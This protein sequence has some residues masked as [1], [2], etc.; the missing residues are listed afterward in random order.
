M[1]GPEQPRRSRLTHAMDTI[2]RTT[3]RIRVLQATPDAPAAENPVDKRVSNAVP[4]DRGISNGLSDDLSLADPVVDSGSTGDDLG[5]RSNGPRVETTTKTQ[6]SADNDGIQIEKSLI[7]EISILSETLRRVPGEIEEDAVAVNDAGGIPGETSAKQSDRQIL[8]DK[9]LKAASENNK[10]TAD[11]F[12][13]IYAALPSEDHAVP[14]LK[15]P[16]APLGNRSS[17]AEAVL[18]SESKKGGMILFIDGTLPGHNETG[19]TPYFDKAIKNLFGIIPLTIF[20]KDWQTDAISDHIRKQSRVNEKNGEYTGYTYPNEW[21]QSFAKW[22]SNH[23]NFLVTFRDVYDHRD[24]AVWIVK[25][26]ENVDNIIAK[27]GF[28]TGFRYDIQVRQN[29]FAFRKKQDGVELMTDISILRS[30]IRDEA[31]SLT[32]KLDELDFSDNPYVKG[33]TKSEWDP[34]TGKPKVPKNQRWNTD[35]EIGRGGKGGNQGGSEYG[36]AGGGQ[37]QKSNWGGG[38]GYGNRNSDNNNGQRGGGY[39]K[40]GWNKDSSGGSKGDRRNE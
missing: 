3:R 33:G 30:T 15:P 32:R 8:W 40:G 38:N 19:F 6:R 36:G 14:A 1:A 24:F 4:V 29:A 35:N 22:T 28:L 31:W 26:K 39:G 23:R 34:K 7:P 21:T 16:S 27:D 25:H 5:E 18:Q 12:L 10:I 9:V 20:D 17:S 2:Q 13:R 37:K 11:F